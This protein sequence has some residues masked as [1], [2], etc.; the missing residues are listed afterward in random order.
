MK[1][2]LFY[3]WLLSILLLICVGFIIK[4]TGLT[5]EDKLFYLLMG[6]PAPAFLFSIIPDFSR[7]IAVETSPT[8]CSTLK[9]VKVLCIIAISISIC[10]TVICVVAI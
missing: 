3:K 1:I 5:T 2:N 8:V 7:Q 9:V 6:I 4:L 10:L